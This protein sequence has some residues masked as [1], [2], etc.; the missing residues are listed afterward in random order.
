MPIAIASYETPKR[1]LTPEIVAAQ[2]AAPQPARAA[3]A[4]EWQGS[5]ATATEAAIAEAAHAYEAVLQQILT[6]HVA[7][8]KAAR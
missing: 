2:G 7:A 6:A 8:I 4:V 1:P 5:D 3:L